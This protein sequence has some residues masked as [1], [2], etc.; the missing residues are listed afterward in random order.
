M[1][2]LIASHRFDPVHSKEARQE[3]VVVLYAVFVVFG[4]EVQQQIHFLL[5]HSLDHEAVISGDEEYAS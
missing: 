2:Y 5:P 4:D 3:G 1:V